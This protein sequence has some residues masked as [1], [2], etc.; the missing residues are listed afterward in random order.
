MRLTGPGRGEV[1]KQRHCANEK[2]SPERLLPGF[3]C[4]YPSLKALFT[5]L[6]ALAGI[7]GRQK[8]CWFW[9]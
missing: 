7:G 6:K 4:R 9:K 2:K 5:G 3:F 8:I 1:F